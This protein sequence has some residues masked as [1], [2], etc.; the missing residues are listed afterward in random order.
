M[1]K[2]G[3]FAFVKDEEDII[4]SFILHNIDIF[5]NITIID[6]GSID[7]TL[8]ILKEYS[9]KYKHIDIYHDHSSFT[10]KGDICSAIMKNSTSDILVPLDA[11]EKI[12]YDNNKQITVNKSTIKNYLQNLE[13]TG[14]KYKINKIYEYHPDN[15]GWYGLAGHTKIIFPQKTF[16]Y[17]DTGFHRGRTTLDESSDFDD[18]HYWRAMF[19]NSVPLDKITK[20][21]ISYIHYHFRSK[22]KWLSKTEAKLKARLGENWN[23]IDYLQQY[24]G[25]SLHMKNRYLK[26]LQTNQWIDCDKTIFL[27]KEIN[28]L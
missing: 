7:G 4:E 19:R 9:S 10:F 20:I 14:F 15:D 23:N 16:M 2:L 18:P 28:N 27:G 3:L 12:I 17:T 13:I 1:N 24:N 26:Y 25:Q 6:N 21:D 5:D 11:D 8:D 22:E